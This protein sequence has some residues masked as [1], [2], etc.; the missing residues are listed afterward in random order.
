MTVED[1][2]GS[3]SPNR[4]VETFAASDGYPFRVTA[5]KVAAGRKR[6][7][8]TVV[9]HGVQSHA[10]WYDNLGRTLA[11]AG[12]EAIFPD[13][14]GSGSNTRDRGDAPSARRLIQDVA[15]LLETQKQSD[16]SLPTALAGIS[17]G[18][19]IA[20]TTAAKHPE[21]VDALALLCP[22]LTPRVGVDRLERIDIALSLLFRPRKLFDIPL[23]DPALFTANPDRRAFIAAD[24]LSI[25][26]ATARL[27]A[28]SFFLDL[29]VRRA[30][31]RVRQPALLML[32]GQDRIVDNES[33]LE[34]FNRLPVVD[35]RVI[36]YPE[37]HHTLEFEPDPTLHARELAEW[38][39][40]AFSSLGRDRS[41]EAKINL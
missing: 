39:A 19:K 30:A 27:L 24:P 32:A 2:S 13:R 21:L 22:G 5:W 18:G 11:E 38:I 4:L 23:G 37:A 1:S 9:L 28:A 7:G 12:L 6:L 35:R 17:W 25:R 41:G 29:A 26:Q 10:G 40:T 15:E 20:L 8:R 14:R 36:V 34:Y 3:P 33:T 16:P 31:E